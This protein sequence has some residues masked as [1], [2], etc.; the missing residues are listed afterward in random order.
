M[1]LRFDWLVL[2]CGMTLLISGWLL[3][4]RSG[5][6][7]VAAQ[8]GDAAP[9]WEYGSVVPLE[10]DVRGWGWQSKSYLS[11]DAQRPFYNLAKERLFNDE[12]ITSYTISS[13]N[14]DLFCEVSL[15]FDY[16]WFEMQHSTMSF[17]EVRRMLLACPR[18]GAAPFIRVPDALEAT[19]QK[20]TDLGSLGII[21]P[22][23]DDALEARDAA[24]FLSISAFRPPECGWRLG[25]GDLGAARHRLSNHD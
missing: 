23:V 24:R 9:A 7:D 11:L 2:A 15:H 17:D 10:P 3:A 4:E 13:Y 5:F 18:A 22:T 20:A 14:P 8:R 19:I 12:Q 1:R 21:V 16:V 6:V 25:P